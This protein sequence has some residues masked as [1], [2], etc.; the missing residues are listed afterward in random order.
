MTRRGAL[1]ISV[2]ATLC[3]G[4]CASGGGATPDPAPV[5]VLDTHSGL[6]G[7]WEGTY[8]SRETGRVGSVTFALSAEGDSAVG[9]VVMVPR[10]TA[11]TVQPSGERWR[12]EGVEGPQVLTI[13]FVRL[14]AAE[15]VGELDPYLDPDCGCTLQTTFRGEVEGDV[16]SGT[17][18]SSAPDPAYDAEGT[19]RVARRPAVRN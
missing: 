13:R 18:E 14:G 10:G 7:V 16:V 8:E 17:F 2:F 4:G 19:W 9:E 5:Y 3:L 6:A 12:W 11:V 15:V 1:A